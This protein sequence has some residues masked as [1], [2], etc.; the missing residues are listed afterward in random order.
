MPALL[1]DLERSSLKM[2]V[3]SPSMIDAKPV[4]SHFDANAIKPLTYTGEKYGSIAGLV[5]WCNQEASALTQEDQI[6][7]GTFWYA[8]KLFRNTGATEEAEVL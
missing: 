5:G 2:F 8:S 7:A 6:T 3:P 4:V 1:L